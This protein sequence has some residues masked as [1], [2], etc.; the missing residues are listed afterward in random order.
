MVQNVG[1]TGLITL[2]MT[3][4]MFILF[5]SII[6]AIFQIRN[7]TRDTSQKLDELSRL[8]SEYISRKS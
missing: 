1:Y 6:V 2:V 4:L 8:L 3:L 7:H 5:F